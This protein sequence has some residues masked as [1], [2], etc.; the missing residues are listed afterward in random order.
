[1]DGLVAVGLWLVDGKHRSDDC[2]SCMGSKVLEWS[3]LEA[4]RQG[5]GLR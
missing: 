4:R 1:M 5:L 2:Y 3:R